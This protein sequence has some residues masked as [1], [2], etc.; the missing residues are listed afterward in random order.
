MK[1]NSDLPKQHFDRPLCFSI[2]EHISFSRFSRPYRD[3]AR[4]TQPFFSQRR[5]IFMPRLS[6]AA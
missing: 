2:F 3:A 5:M 6:M 4:A 1:Q